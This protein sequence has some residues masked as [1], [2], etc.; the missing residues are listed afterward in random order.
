MKKIAL[1]IDGSNIHASAKALGFQVDYKKLLAHYQSKNEVVRAFYFSALP[2]KNVRS[3]LRPMMT[4]L[5]HNGYTVI[6]KET[7]EFISDEGFFKE[8]GNMDCEIAVYACKFATLVE[9]IVLFSGDG[10]FRCVVERVQELGTRCHVV[11]TLKGRM[12]ADA[13]RRQADTFTELDDIRKNVEHIQKESV[14]YRRMH[15][16]N[17]PRGGQ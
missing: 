6:S 10:D 11:S 5:E 8:K 15:F 2:P 7:K 13:L 14:P 3:T 16:L 1:L 9:E 17:V 12:V 4:F